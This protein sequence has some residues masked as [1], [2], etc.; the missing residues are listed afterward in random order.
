MGFVAVAALL[1]LQLV[2]H[3][4]PRGFAGPLQRPPN[5]LIIV[6]D[7]Q[8]ASEGALKVMRRTRSWFANKGTRFEHAF[9]TTPLCCPARATIFSGRYAHNH[10]VYTNIGKPD[11]DHAFTIQDYLKDAGYKTALTGKFFNDW[12]L[13]RRPPHFDRW[14]MFDG[15]FYRRRFNVD[16]EMR[17]VPGY[18]TTFIRNKSLDF[19]HSFEDANDRTPWFLFVAPY[20]PHAPFTPAPEHESAR[21]PEWNGNPAVFEKNRSDKPPYVLIRN[22]TF[23]T[24]RRNRKLQ[25]R[26]LKSVDELVA[27]ITEALRTLDESRRTLVF[28]MSDNGYM[29]A[30]H[31]LFDKGAPYTPSIR[32]P[33]LMRYPRAGNLPSVDRRIVA[34]VD[35]AP[36]VLDAA[37]VAADPLHPMD[38]KSLL[39]PVWERNR[40]LTEYRNNDNIWTPPTWASTRTKSIQYV[41]YYDD[42][43]TIFREL[44]RLR[45]DPWQLRNVLADG[46]AGND[47]SPAR[48]TELSSRLTS[49]RNCEGATC[50]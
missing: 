23:K 40:I 13:R 46:R 27:A 30:D 2:P 17:S 15:G 38:G 48:L 26:S 5:V 9:A 42:G 34:N 4:A 41:E 31:G 21:V 6:T 7:D 43:D 29:W 35:I 45:R 32:I 49:D 8:R 3:E 36:T 28:F 39:T 18:S 25:L 44:Y 22:E 12:P 50:P 33:M 11:F 20:A 16:G 14:A 37:G 19:L 47:P 24:W 1:V 10:G